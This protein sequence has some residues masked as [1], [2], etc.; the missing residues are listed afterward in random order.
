MMSGRTSYMTMQEHMLLSGYS[1]PPPWAS[2]E[3]CCTSLEPGG[4]LKSPGSLS[5]AGWAGQEEKISDRLRDL[6]FPHAPDRAMEPEFLFP[7]VSHPMGSCIGP[8]CRSL[9]PSSGSSMGC[10]ACFQNTRR[11]VFCDSF[12]FQR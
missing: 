4:T 11:L 2:P 6:P 5:C 7:L 9:A 3:M 1:P 8:G 10:F 12:T